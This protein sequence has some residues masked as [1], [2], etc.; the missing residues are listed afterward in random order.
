MW[1][2]TRSQCSKIQKPTLII[3]NIPQD[4]TVENLEGTVL[5]QNRFEHQTSG[6]RSQI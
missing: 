6:D 4:I 3:C 5:T 1:W 2:G